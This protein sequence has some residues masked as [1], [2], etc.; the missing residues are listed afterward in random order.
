MTFLID[1]YNLLHALGLANRRMGRGELARARQRLI[2]WLDESHSTESD[3]IHVVFDARNAE[4][5]SPGEQ[6][7]SKVHVTYSTGQFADDLIEEMI[8]AESQP[9]HMTVVSNDSRLL[10]AARRRGC[11]A[12]TSGEYIDS[13]TAHRPKAAK[14]AGDQSD[15]P[16]APD[17]Q[18]MA[19]WL[20]QFGER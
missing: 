18:E 20:R 5:A 6:V 3:S 8:A 14:P 13:L 2:D 10:D 12:A 16:D 4:R 9:R 7:T 15:K 17:E 11:V 19:E 1:G